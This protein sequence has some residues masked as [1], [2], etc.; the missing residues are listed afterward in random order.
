MSL[1]GNVEFIEEIPSIKRHGA[2]G[3]GLYRTEML[4]FN[5]D[6]LPG[7]EEQYQAYAAIVREMAPAPVTIRTLDV[8]GD[9]ILTDLNLGDEM[10]PALGVR[11]IRLSLRQIDIFKTQLRA[12]L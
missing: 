11:A 6:T 5:R 10:N 1:K 12:I 3:V 8:G 4:F 9:K 7:E 2:E